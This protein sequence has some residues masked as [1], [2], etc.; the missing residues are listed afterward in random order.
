M[1]WLT[2]HLVWPLILL[3]S[4]G[5]GWMIDTTDWEQLR[6]QKA[7]LVLGAIF[8]FFTSFAACL[9]ALLGPTPPFQGNHLNQLEATS[10]FLLPAV[11]AIISAVALVYLYATGV[12][13]RFLVYLY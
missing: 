7:F 13:V 5:L 10:A 2:Y 1:P 6:Q 12:G 3:A 4:W 8:V 9:I 11:A